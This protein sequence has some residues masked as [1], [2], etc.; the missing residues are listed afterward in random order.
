[1]NGEGRSLSNIDLGLSE[2]NDSDLLGNGD[3]LLLRKNEDPDDPKD[4]DED[5][6]KDELLLLRNVCPPPGRA[7]NGAP[8]NEPAKPHPPAKTQAPNCLRLMLPLRPEVR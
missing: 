6:L 2:N 5:P 1:M 7:A 3:S 4:D 8:N